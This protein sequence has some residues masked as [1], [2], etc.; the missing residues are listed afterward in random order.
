[1]PTTTSVAAA[2]LGIAA[3]ISNAS[4]IFSPVFISNREAQ[5]ANQ[6]VAPFAVQVNAVD[7]FDP[8]T[9]NSFRY[10]AY[11]WDFGETTGPGVA[12]WGTSCADPTRSRNLEY[13]PVAGHVYQVAGNYTIT[14]SIYSAITKTLH[15]YTKNITVLAANT[16]YSGTNTVCFSNNTD[17]TGAPAGATLVPNITTTTAMQP[18]I[19]DGVR[20]ML[21][22]DHTFT[23]AANVD[24]LNFGTHT[25]GTICSFGS[26]TVKPIIDFT[27]ASPSVTTAAGGGYD[28]RYYDLIVRCNAANTTARGIAVGGVGGTRYD[29]ETKGFNLILRVDFI[30]LAN[31]V[32]V[33]GTGQAVQDCTSTGMFGGAGNV[34]IYSIADGMKDFYCA[35]NNWD[36]GFTGEHTGRFQGLFNAKFTAN[37]WTGAASTKTLLAVR[38]MVG[39][40]AGL[41]TKNVVIEN[42]FFDPS[43]TTL[44]TNGIQCQSQNTVNYEPIESV[45]IQHCLF[46]PFTVSADFV[47]Y[48]DM[49]LQVRANGTVRHC[50][51]LHNSPDSPTTGKANHT[52]IL[53]YGTQSGSPNEPTNDLVIANISLYSNTKVRESMV[54]EQTATIIAVPTNVT[55]QDCV[56]Y[57]AISAG[58][59]P[60][61]G[62]CEM[63]T[64]QGGGIV[65]ALNNTTTVQMKA[66]DPLFA[67]PTSYAG[68]TLQSGSYGLTSST[69][70]GRIGI[71]YSPIAT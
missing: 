42:D 23:A 17:F 67:A 31:A 54:N 27:L 36:R 60:G 57:T 53:I 40:S 21:H 18:Y 47:S 35:G 33:G 4:G 71:D 41:P 26:G 1:M 11:A 44:C 59:S 62:V 55:V 43:G 28:W 56:A 65:L 20:L 69:K 2:V 6:G 10:C 39:A 68:F 16:V 70:G 24:V 9:I 15:T 34:A 8:E 46:G 61:N 25:G 45:L 66:T 63:V 50:V 5:Y 51:M 32:L 48:Q 14:L 12:A 7:T 22:W 52:G 64:A 37:R 29:L 38:G 19:A 3:G 58:N 30:S 49:L 13:G